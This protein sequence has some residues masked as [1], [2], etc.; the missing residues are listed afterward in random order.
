MY[1]CRAYV[2][3]CISN[4]LI[5]CCRITNSTERRCVC[6]YNIPNRGMKCSLGGNKVFPSWES[7]VPLLGTFFTCYYMVF[8]GLKM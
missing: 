7:I 3:L 5:R 4:A 2:L 1:G 8:V 6:F